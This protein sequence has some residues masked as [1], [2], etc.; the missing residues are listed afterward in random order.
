[1]VDAKS[2]QSHFKDPLKA[3]TKNLL[4]TVAR[5]VFQEAF[6]LGFIKDDPSYGLVRF[7]DVEI[8]EKEIFT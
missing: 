2:K 1:L 6:D 8:R 3:N 5:N 4:I 7:R